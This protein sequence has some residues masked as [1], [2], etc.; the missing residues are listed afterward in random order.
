[1]GT[2]F[3]RILWLDITKIF[4]ASLS[5]LNHKDLLKPTK[6]KVKKNVN[7]EA[8]GDIYVNLSQ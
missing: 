5:I 8:S 1:M 3:I 2:L 4:N 7:A 6:L